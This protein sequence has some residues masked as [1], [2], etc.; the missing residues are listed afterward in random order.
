MLGFKM[1]REAVEKLRKKRIG[2]K[3]SEETKRKMSA[4]QKGRKHTDDTKE[5]MRISKMGSQNPM[6]A[7]TH[8]PEAIEKI[9]KRSNELKNTPKAL[10]ALELGRKW[11]LGKKF[12]DE[13]RQ[14][15][16][17]AKAKSR[18]KIIRFDP[19]TQEEFIYESL[20]SVKKD[21]FHTGHVT[22]CCKGIVKK[23]KGYI[24]RYA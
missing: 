8:S 20:N 22:E 17:D 9:R 14:K 23:H 15:L 16:R 21:N 13:H 19:L 12:T 5:A 1:P 3:A 24:W 7:N 4:S 2:K 10:A 6:Y 11:A 18:K